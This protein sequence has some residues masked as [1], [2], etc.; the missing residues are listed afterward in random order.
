MQLSRKKIGDM[1][2]KAFWFLANPHL[3]LCWGIAWLI[4]N[5]WAYLLLGL[6]IYLGNTP[7]QAVGGGYLAF[8]WLP[9]TPEKIVTTIIAIFL[10]KWLFPKDEKTLGVLKGLLEKAKAKLHRRSN[11]KKKEKKKVQSSECRVQSDE[12]TL[13]RA[14][15]DALDKH[16][17][18]MR[19]ET[20]KEVFAAVRENIKVRKD[21]ERVRAEM[22]QSRIGEVKHRYAETSYIALLIDIEEMERRIVD[23]QR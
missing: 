14:E 23:E 15:I 1:I 16:N 17:A 6:G 5:G 8:L 13:T 18:R 10:L 9:V 2:R 4:T 22:A 19:E 20:I 3:L 7:M 11:K 21:Q 12:V